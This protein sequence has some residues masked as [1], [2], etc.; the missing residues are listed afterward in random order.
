MSTRSKKKKK[1]K[2]VRVPEQMELEFPPIPS[3]SDLT[4]AINDENLM[5]LIHT[6][7]IE[8]L[9]YLIHAMEIYKVAPFPPI[10]SNNHD[11]TDAMDERLRE[12]NNI[13]GNFSSVEVE[14]IE[15][16]PLPTS[17]NATWHNDIE[18][19]KTMRMAMSEQIIIFL[20]KLKTIMS[21]K[22]TS[23]QPDYIIYKMAKSIEFW[24]YLKY[25]KQPSDG[26]KHYQEI[27]MY[28]NLLHSEINIFLKMLGSQRTQRLR[29][30]YFL[31]SA[32]L[33]GGGGGGGGSSASSSGSSASSGSGGSS[34]SSGGGLSLGAVLGLW[35]G[36]PIQLYQLPTVVN[37]SWRETKEIQDMRIAM[38]IKIIIA[39][40]TLDHEWFVHVRA[41]DD[42]IYPLAARIELYFFKRCDK[43]K[44]Q[45]LY[46]DEILVKT[47]VNALLNQMKRKYDQARGSNKRRGDGGERGGKRQKGGSVNSM[48][49]HCNLLMH[50]KQFVAPH[51]L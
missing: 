10:P 21:F 11:L 39:M 32:T 38:S 14:K 43:A 12:M 29:D 36:R 2:V 22:A 45:M 6:M 9:M 42:K 7:E 31:A 37:G 41:P 5:Y 16:F 26:A 17:I 48:L 27:F 51:R 30:A 19:I 46:Q 25:Q 23:S 33:A 13:H 24:F 28:E 34:S 44:Y 40:K 8:N 49:A 47:K 3:D 20:K 4:V 50:G 15:L 18:E 1:K 35:N